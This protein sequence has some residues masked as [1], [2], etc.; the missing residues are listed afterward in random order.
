MFEVN[1]ALARVD[2]AER[3]KDGLLRLCNKLQQSTTLDECADVFLNLN[4]MVCLAVELT[5]SQEPSQQLKRILVVSRDLLTG[6]VLLHR[7]KRDKADFIEAIKG[8]FGCNLTTTLK[9]QLC[10]SYAKISSG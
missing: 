6:R 9:S 3:H 1:T 5:T 10:A 2:L 7:N 4:D 8:L